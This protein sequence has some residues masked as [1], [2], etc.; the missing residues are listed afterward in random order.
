[1][2]KMNDERTNKKLTYWNVKIYWR[3]KEKRTDIVNISHT[4]SM[5]KVS[6]G[7]QHSLNKQEDANHNAVNQLNEK[8]IY[9]LNWISSRNQDK[10][11]KM[12]KQRRKTL[13]TFECKTKTKKGAMKYTKKASKHLNRKFS[14]RI[15]LNESQ[16][17]N[18][19]WQVQL[20]RALMPKRQTNELYAH[21]YKVFNRVQRVSW[22][23]PKKKMKRMKTIRTMR[24]QKQREREKR[25]NCPWDFLF[26]IW[27][28]YESIVLVMYLD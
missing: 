13:T 20:P 16:C 25:S 8:T 22:Y 19:S 6:T 24:E 23:V 18:C 11:R 7:S 4:R 14:D 28:G 1:M 3:Y 21:G 9:I 10:I 27:I 2:Y 5:I 26:H 15:G 17:K 12:K